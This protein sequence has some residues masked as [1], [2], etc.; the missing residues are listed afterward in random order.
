MNAEGRPFKILFVCLANLCRSPFAEAIARKRH[1]RS[2]EPASAGIA[3]QGRPFEEAVEVAER[4][5]GADLS[6]H[7]PRHVLEFPLDDFD[8]IIAMDSSVF[9]R[10]SSMNEV[11]PE[12]LYGWEI[13]DP[14]GL[15]VDAYEAAARSI[16]RE[17][18]AFL[19]QRERDK[20]RAR[21]RA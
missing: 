1:G 2:I 20:L 16:E 17:I 3:P 10:L 18:D 4:L 21:G 12:K 13:A 5:F 8:F 14:C 7:R 9:M 15:G 11:P 6:G 19:L